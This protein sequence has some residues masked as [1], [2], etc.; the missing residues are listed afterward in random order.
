MVKIPFTSEDE[1]W[2]PD[3]PGISFDAALLAGTLG[4]ARRTVAARE[5]V[6]LGTRLVRRPQALAGPLAKLAG[7]SARIAT[8]RS[9]IDPGSP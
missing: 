8:G 3:P 2:F 4:V 1:G 5:A 9:K 7:E 6:T